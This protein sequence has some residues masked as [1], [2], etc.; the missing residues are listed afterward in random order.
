[1]WGVKTRRS[2][3]ERALKVF[4]SFLIGEWGG[5]HSCWRGDYGVGQEGWFLIWEVAVEQARFNYRVQAKRL[6]TSIICEKELS[7]EQQKPNEKCC[8]R[9]A[10]GQLLNPVCLWVRAVENERKYGHQNHSQKSRGKE[11]HRRK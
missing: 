8:L 9:Y 10:I 4:Q 11:D 3:R 6:I 7:S 5:R 2:G 1:M